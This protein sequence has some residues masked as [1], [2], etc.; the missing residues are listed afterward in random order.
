MVWWLHLHLVR[1]C[2][3]NFRT[4]AEHLVVSSVAQMTVCPTTTLPGGEVVLADGSCP[5]QQYHYGS[6][7]GFPFHSLPCLGILH[8]VVP[9]SCLQQPPSLTNCPLPGTPFIGED[10]TCVSLNVNVTASGQYWGHLYICIYL[11]SI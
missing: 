5:N 10:V 1:N 11:F 6:K 8:G 4:F 2:H 3:M 9:A 7:E